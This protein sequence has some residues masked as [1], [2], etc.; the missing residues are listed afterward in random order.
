MPNTAVIT[1]GRFQPIT[2]GHEKLVNKIKSFAAQINADPLVFLSHSHDNNKNPLDYATKFVLA[3]YAFG[4]CVYR[5]ESKTILQAL[6]EL[7]HQYNKI[8]VFVG[9]D[10]VQE[11][12][13]LL[14][15]YNSIEYNYDCITIASAGQRDASLGEVEG[16]SGTKLR[17]YA[18]AKDAK[19]FMKG[20]PTTLHSHVDLVMHSIRKGLKV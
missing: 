9:S 1:F 13:T 10:R 3:R 7:N 4:S 19:S 17:E 2:I 6:Q 11:F 12:D 15:K 8:V 18:I 20:L 14:N 5:S 16:M